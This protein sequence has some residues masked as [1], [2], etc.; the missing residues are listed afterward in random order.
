MV[1]HLSAIFSFVPKPSIMIVSSLLT[2]IDL[3]CPK[4]DASAFSNYKPKSSVTTVPPV[5]IAISFKIAFLLS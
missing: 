2:K 3:H 5:K 4:T 1:S